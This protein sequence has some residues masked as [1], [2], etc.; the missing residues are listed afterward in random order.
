[1]RIYVVYSESG[2]Y[3][4]YSMEIHRAF[5]TPERAEQYADEHNAE[6]A[7]DH[8]TFREEFDVMEMEVEE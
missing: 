8:E 1:M 2:A 5:T 4:D 3:E 7:E 6:S